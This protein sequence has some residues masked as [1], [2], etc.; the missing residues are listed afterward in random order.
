MK[1]FIK[2]LC[3]AASVGMLLVFAGCN[4]GTKINNPNGGTSGK[5]NTGKQTEIV[6]SNWGDSEE[7][8]IFENVFDKFMA[9]NPDIKVKY[10]YIPHSEYI[11]KLN[12][13]AATKTLPDIGQMIEFNSLQWAENEMFV[14]VRHLYDEGKIKPRLESV[15][16][17]KTDKGFLGSSFITEIYTLFYDKKYCDS[18]GVK[19]PATVDEAWTWDE[20]LNA[21][22]KLTVDVNGKHP[23]ET[24]FNPDKIKVYAISDMPAELVALNNGGGI[25]NEDCT[26]IWLDKPETIKAFQMV[27]DLMNVHYVA[28]RPASRSAIGGGNNV[29]LTG[30]VAMSYAGQYNLLWYKQYIENGTLDIGF[31]V[32]PVLKN[33]VVTTSGPAIVVFK[34]S[35]N[36]E[37]AMKLL[38]YFYK[39]ENIMDAIR[40]GLW[41]PSEKSYYENEKNINDWIGNS[42]IHQNGYKTAVLDVAR[43]NAVAAL[44]YKLANYNEVMDIIYG[45]M[46]QVWSGKKTAEAVIKNEIM[47]NLK[48]LMNSYWK[49]RNI[50]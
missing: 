37:A 14:D 45:P 12:A 29:L 8:K 48:N 38:E 6:F 24:G 39:T 7:K 15:T 25:F 33:Y 16:F 13:M 4:G 41:M 40:S 27:A 50:K 1:I 31:G 43:E 11:T 22:K 26:E 42:K 9:D 47:P 46:D 20:F 49:E 23:G 2:I 3:I 44:Y 36:Q 28:P 10:L 17:N 32:G 21:A 35:K 5:N 18:M 30:K 19:V 34:Q